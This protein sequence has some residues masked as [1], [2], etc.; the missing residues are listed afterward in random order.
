LGKNLQKF[1]HGAGILAELVAE[2]LGP[3]LLGVAT[4]T[5]HA[6]GEALVVEPEER[7]FR[8]ETVQQ[9]GVNLGVGSKRKLQKLGV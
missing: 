9:F 3:V 2:A 5:E 7:L 4:N 8:W 1:V 6:P